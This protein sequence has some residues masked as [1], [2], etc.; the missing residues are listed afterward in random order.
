MIS[1]R[2]GCNIHGCVGKLRATAIGSGTDRV[3]EVANGTL[4]VKRAGMATV[5]I[6][7]LNYEDPISDS[8]DGAWS[9]S[10]GGTHVVTYKILRS[11]VGS[12]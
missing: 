7:D 11:R 1:G 8:A 2:G 6:T 5:L 3:V 9:E 4:E 10:W 12:P